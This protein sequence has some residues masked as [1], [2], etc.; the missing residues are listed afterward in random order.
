[1]T[2]SQ[3]EYEQNEI[4]RFYKEVEN[5]TKGNPRSYIRECRDKLVSLVKEQPD[6]VVDQFTWVLN[7]S[8]GAGAYY[9][10]LNS[11]RSQ[12]ILKSKRHLRSVTLNMWRLYC[13]LEFHLSG[14]LV[15]KALKDNFSTDQ[16]EE[17]TEKLM[18]AVK[19][20]VLNRA[21]DLKIRIQEA[22]KLP[23]N[24]F[25]RHES[26]LHILYSKEVN[27]WLAKNYEFYGNCVV[28]V[29]DVKGQPWYNRRFFDIPFAAGRK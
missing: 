16:I 12:D 21:T 1:M 8:Y 5:N 28:C 11:I 9:V 2:F 23:E 29:S 24:H 25:D 6:F 14:R 3:K 4:D 18:E 26:D 20:D 27:D 13:G 10:Y 19:E 15:F 17:F 7:G 22:L